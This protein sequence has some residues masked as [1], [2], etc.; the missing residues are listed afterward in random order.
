[1]NS[2]FTSVCRH[3][4]TTPIPV[5]GPPIS[6][7]MLSFTFS[8]ILILFKSWRPASST[9]PSETWSFLRKWRPSFQNSKSSFVAQSPWQRWLWRPRYIL[10]FRQIHGY[11]FECQERRTCATKGISQLNVDF[12]TCSESDERNDVLSLYKVPR[13]RPWRFCGGIASFVPQVY[14]DR[15][16]SRS[17]WSI[18]ALHVSDQVEIVCILKSAVHYCPQPCWSRFRRL[19]ILTFLWTPLNMLREKAD[20]LP[21]RIYPL[22]WESFALTLT[23]MSLETF[24]DCIRAM[25]GISKLVNLRKLDFTTIYIDDTDRKRRKEILCDICKNAT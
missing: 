3:W 25:N 22:L 21:L 1:M 8:A 10:W 4:P 13:A 7:M 14:N 18:Q 23:M 12:S 24:S 19:L 6:L 11:S 20:S 17:L 5:H 9:V 15:N 2:K 16:T